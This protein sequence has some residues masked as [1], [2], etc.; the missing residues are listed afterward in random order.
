MRVEPSQFVLQHHVEDAISIH[1]IRPPLF[2]A[3]NHAV[4]LLEGIQSNHLFYRVTSL[5]Q[6]L[7]LLAKNGTWVSS[8]VNATCLDRHE[9]LVLLFQK[10]IYVLSQYSCLVRLCDVAVYGIHL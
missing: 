4:V 9:E 6:N 10:R 8:Y 3:S 7:G 1:G 2:P 5:L